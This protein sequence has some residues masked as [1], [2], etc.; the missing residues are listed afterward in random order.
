MKF[1]ALCFL[2]V[3]ACALCEMGAMA[4][5]SS[6]WKE[7]VQAAT[8]IDPEDQDPFPQQIVTGIESTLALPV[9]LAT[10]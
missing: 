6:K 3:V 7:E 9:E 4:S 1:Y 10:F 2:A 5:L 8:G